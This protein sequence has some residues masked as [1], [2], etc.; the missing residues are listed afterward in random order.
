MSGGAP[1]SIMNQG[2][3]VV[4]APKLQGS[5]MSKPL[6]GGGLINSG[7]GMGSS[8]IL[9][10]PVLGQENVL[11]PTNRGIKGIESPKQLL[12]HEEGK[13]SGSTFEASPI[14]TG[15]SAKQ[16]SY[17]SRTNNENSILSPTS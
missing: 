2:Q 3:K 7:S 16:P 9:N 6:G 1:S 4:I 14:I 11:M 5:L 13:I 10:L 12:R 17:Y 8:S 15:P